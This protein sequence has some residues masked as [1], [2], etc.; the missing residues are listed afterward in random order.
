MVLCSGTGCGIGA[1]P[2][3]GN[4][5]VRF[6]GA[7]DGSAPYTASVSQTITIP[8]GSIAT[9]SYYMK[10]ATLSAPA[11]STVAITV[12]GSVVQTVP[13]PAVADL[14]YV[15]RTVDLSAFADGVPRALSF[16]YNRP[17]SSGSDVFLID[18]AAVGINCGESTA[19]V[20]GRVFNPNGVGLQNATVILTNTGGVQ[21]TVTTS[22]FGFFSFENVPTTQT[23]MLSV[24]SKR[25]RYSARNMFVT[26]SMTNIDLWGLQ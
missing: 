17:A 15:L 12:G 11:S 5:Y 8:A 9:L 21:R 18:D 10:A 24:R 25:Y 23:Y 14:D 22:S 4:G 20:S 6:D 1:V 2:R 3:A 7:T 19:T 16:V 26:A 13:E